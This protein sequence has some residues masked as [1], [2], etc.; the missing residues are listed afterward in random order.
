MTTDTRLNPHPDTWIEVC[1]AGIYCIP[2][3]AYIDPM[4]PVARALITHGHAD[5]A[6]GGHESVWATVETINIMQQRYGI[7]HAV[8]QTAVAI[9]EEINLTPEAEHPVLMSLYPAGHILGSAQIKLTYQG[10]SIVFA[11]DYKRTPDPSCPAFMPIDCDVFVTE[12]T[13]ALP[14]FN[15][16]PI[17]DEM[18]KLMV[19]LARFPER[20]HLVGAYALGKCQRVILGLRQYGYHKPIYLHGAL[21][22]LCQTYRDFGYDL[23]ECIA[24]SDVADYNTLAGEIVIAPP[25]ALTDRW[26]RKLP[27]VLTCMAS[28]WMQIRARTKQKRAELPLII[29]DHCDW[30]ELLDT[31]DEIC[32]AEVWITHGREDALMHACGKMDIHARALR[33]IGYEDESNE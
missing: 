7:E 20:C 18:H 26:S 16:P 30:Q 13:F 28:G 8:V 17:Q 9:G 22:K 32:P 5:H 31:L 10:V 2:A 12:A 15:H 1:R 19:S 3:D 14:V 27:D 6:R 24:V 29:S 25:S 33:L 11:G 21:L 4:Q 23:G